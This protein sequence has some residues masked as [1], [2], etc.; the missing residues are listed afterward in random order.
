MGP[1]PLE[2]CPGA[3]EVEPQQHKGGSRIST[4]FFFFSSQEKP[5]EKILS[6]SVVKFDI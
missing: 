4:L 6:V 3:A 1:V 5:L 2:L